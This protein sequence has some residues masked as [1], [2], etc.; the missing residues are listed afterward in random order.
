MF[1]EGKSGNPNGRPPG[2]LNR[3]TKTV[4]EVILNTFNDLQSHETANL[5]TWAEENPTEFYKIA[6]KLI[7]TE[8]TATVKDHRNPLE[9]Y[10]EQTID[11]AIISIES[12]PSDRVEE[13]EV[14]S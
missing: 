13:T 11:A 14:P 10:D 9:K 6:S 8:I 1:E 12:G 7:P 5:K 2:S 4:R 3:L